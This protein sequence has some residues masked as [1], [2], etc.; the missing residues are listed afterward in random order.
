MPRPR[1]PFVVTVAA[2]AGVLSSSCTTSGSS[3]NP[4]YPT[5]SDAGDA[6]KIDTD[7]DSEAGDTSATDSDS[8]EAQP[9]ECPEGDPGFGSVKKPCTAASAIRCSYDDLCPTRP[10]GSDRNVYGCRDDGSG[11]KNWTLTSADY[12]PG[13]PTAQPK[14]GDPCL[15]AVHL[16]Y[17][18]CDYGVCE[19]FTRVVANCRGIDTFDREWHVASIVCNPPEPDGGADSSDASTSEGG[20]G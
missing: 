20:G 3:S 2:V 16:A 17:D 14:S 9:V 15:C 5:N 19:K 10:A 11:T 6:S 7:S 13:C 18:S 4:P 12:S 8:A 1:P